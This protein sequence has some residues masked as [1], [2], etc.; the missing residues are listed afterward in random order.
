MRIDSESYV[1]GA[2]IR[3]PEDA[4]LALSKLAHSDFIESAYQDCFKAIKSLTEASRPLT[5]DSMANELAGNTDAV[6]ALHHAVLVSRGVDAAYYIDQVLNAS[7]LRTLALIHN[8]LNRDLDQGKPAVEIIE[9]TQRELSKIVTTQ[10][11]KE[12]TI[13][14]LLTSFH[15]G[16]SFVDHVKHLVSNNR[17]GSDNFQGF[18]SG[19]KNLD[20]ALGG[21]SN[22]T[23]T[24][25]G[26]TT[27]SG[28][29]TFIINLMMNILKNYPDAA[30]AFFTLEMT[31]TELTYK[32]LGAYTGIPVKK[33]QDGFLNDEELARIEEMAPKVANLNIVLNNE[34][35]AT[36]FS[37]R[38]AFR[39]QHIQY[40]SNIF[41]VDYI[42]RM[43]SST[44]HQNRH[45]EIDAIS[46]TLNDIALEFNIP[47]I[48]LAQ[49]SRNIMNRQDKRPMLS[50]LRE[51]GSLEEHAGNILL[52]HRPKRYDDSI[53]HD[54]TEV[55][56]AK[57]RMH[58]ELGKV[59]FEFSN[60]NLIERASLEEMA[61]AAFH[62]QKKVQIPY[63]E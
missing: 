61:A 24:I 42:T 54:D 15:E 6:A 26:A 39:R 52:L 62:D 63:Y 22:G 11:N 49:L 46:N 19:Y 48:A 5:V 2:S 58:N 18:R 43:R 1:I 53:I 17:Q 9:Q 30:I 34:T 8:K 3:H 7:Q 33:I 47:V 44:K 23:Y 38:N 10:A 35:P 29:T 57:S 32:L 36:D 50:D 27:S 16:R 12:K 59:T 13:E 45:L 55:Y 37:V 56:I 21:F 20:A 4:F 14:D 28:K 60:G 51:S 25:I 31:L 40:G 41:F